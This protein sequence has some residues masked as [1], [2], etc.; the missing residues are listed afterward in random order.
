MIVQFVDNG[1]KMVTFRIFTKILNKNGI[2]KR[3][4]RPRGLQLNHLR[5]ENKQ[6]MNGE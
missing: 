5:A 2:F 4:V 3:I 1:L 6:I